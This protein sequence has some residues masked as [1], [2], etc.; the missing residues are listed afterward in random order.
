MHCEL[1]VPGLFG[2]ASGI[3]APN[4]ELLLARGRVSS[5]ESKSLEAWL[6][7]AFALHDQPMAAGALTLIAGGGVPGDDCWGRTDPVHLRLMRDRLIVVPIAAFALSREESD[8]LVAELNRHFAGALSITAVEPGRWCA[9]LENHFA[10]DTASPIDV[11][12]RDVD[13]TLRIGGEAG[14]RWAKLLNEI[15]MLLNAHPVNQAREARG[16]PAV[17]SVWLWGVGEAP[18]GAQSPWQSVSANDPVALGLA[19]L[20]GARHRPL[21]SSAQ[22]WLERG[23]QGGRHLIVI[24]VLRA[25][26]ALGHSAEYRECIA[27]LEEHWFAP[28]LD[29]LR[30]ERIGMITVHVPDAL[31]ASF[32]TI[33][34]DLRRFWRRPKA[35]EHY[36]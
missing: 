36:A 29:A 8:S 33:R 28:M 24:D 15:Q 14:R 27:A 22:A 12:G 13:V 11:A 34:G 3:R 1:I 6:Q 30:E 35:L 10:F 7:E 20:A 4:L 32:E 26:L 17:N 5:S 16:E 31:G 18:R 21:P 9:R 19:Q 25:P 2:E 23:P